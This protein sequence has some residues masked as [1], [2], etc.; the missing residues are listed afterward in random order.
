MRYLLSAILMMTLISTGHKAFSQ[1]IATDI[2]LS[3]E[4]G[5]VSNIYLN[6]YVP[7][8]DRSLISVFNAFSP[9]VQMRWADA[10][11]SVSL[12]GAGYF[13]SF[14]GDRDGLSG[15]Y[16][17]S[18]YRRRLSPTVTA[19]ASGGL[20]TFSG[21]RY[22]DVQWLQVGAEWA[23]SPFAKVELHVG[24]GWHRVAGLAVSDE[25][26]LENGTGNGADNGGGSG[27]DV[28]NRSDSYR[29]AMEYWPG[30]R[31]RLRAGF[32]SGLGNITRPG[33]GFVS[34]ISAT[35]FMR[36][37]MAVTLATG[38]EQYSQEFQLSP[39]NGIGAPQDG[40]VMADNGTVVALEDRFHRTT[41]SASYPVLA[42][43][44]LTG[45]AAGLLWFSSQ[46]NEVEPDYQ[47]SVGVQ[48]SLSPKRVRKGV[49]RS[50]EWSR[51]NGGEKIVTLRYSGADRLY[52]TG[53]FNDWDLPGIPLQKTG[54]NRF[55]AELELPDGVH[56]YKIGVRDNSSLEW[57]EFPAEVATVSDGF[58]GM[59]GR[60]IIDQKEK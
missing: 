7:D 3:A 24:T 51:R 40:G 9:A 50:L 11:N 47:V 55:R 10:D 1:R 13:M 19:R 45:S 30:Y 15:G 41:L 25:N 58:G 57:L 21:S 5:Y 28:R 12:N 22:R 34:S 8:W 46:D 56:Q 29:L 31:W 44:S 2:F 48:V 23:F 16:L 35:H 20:Q 39:E 52:I 17:S 33:D 27:A 43:V 49:I 42:N 53:D 38:F 59:N 54:R 4:S 32:F 60:V 36:N 6:P 18:T 37:R 26:G 14:F